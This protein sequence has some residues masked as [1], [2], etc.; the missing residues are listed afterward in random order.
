MNTAL[1]TL[2]PTT[3]SLKTNVFGDKY[4]YNLNRGSFEKIS[5]Q[6]I[7]DAEFSKSLLQEDTLNIIIGTDSGLLPKYV[8][9]QGIPSGSRY[10]FIEPEQILEQ[11]HHHKLLEDLSPEIVCTT[12]DR[13]EEQANKFKITEYSYINGVKSFNAICA[14]QAINDEYTELT[15]QITEAIRKLH[16]LHN[17]S[18]GYQPFIIR[19]IENIAEN[20]LPASILANAYDGKTVIILAGGPSLTSVFPWLLENQ[21]RLVIFSVSRISRQLIAA[22]IEPDFVFSVDP[23]NENID[24]SR[25]MFLF[26]DKTIFI[27]SYHVQPSLINQWHGQSLYLGTRLP[28]KSDLNISNLQGCGPTVTNS[29]LSTAHHFGFKKILLAGFDLCFT[30]EGISHAQGS[31]EQ[32][33]GPRYDPTLLDVETYSGEYRPTSHDYYSALLTLANQAKLI[34]ADHREIINLAPTAAKVEHIKHIPTSEITLPDLNPEDIINV[35]QLIPELTNDLLNIHY[36]AAIGELEKAA[37][38]IETIIKLSQKALNINQSMYSAD[39]RIESYKDKRKLDGIERQ[40]QKKHQ[41]YSTLIKKFGV[42][43]FIKINSPHDSD[44]WDAKKAK[45]LGDIYYKAYQAGATILLALINET[46]TRIKARQEELKPIS[47]INV[48]LAQWNLDKSYR[49]ADLWLQ[50]H[51]QQGISQH[52]ALAL[53]PM[54]DRF[55]Q[56]FSSQDTAFKAKVAKTSTLQMLKS[57]IKLLFRYQKIDE[58]KNLRAGFINDSKHTN[59][60][61]YLLLIE[62]YIAELDNNAEV[63]L[64]HYNNIINIEHSPLLEE[65]LLRIASI[66][67]EQQTPEN[68]FLAIECLAQL[69]PLYLPYQADLARILGKIML[70]IDCYNAYINFFPEDTLSKLKLAALYIEI[71]VYEAAELMLAHILKE[72]PDLESAISLKNQL[73]K[74]KEANENTATVT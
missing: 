6:A 27:N 42:R 46:I 68:A 20:I 13:W 59:K 52:T 45:K 16:Q 32:L 47:D 11:L 41:K 17:T 22:G 34:T 58:L 10:I 61:P 21:N 65:A 9:Q 1:F 69:N 43:Q 29:A 36:Q 64:E 53:K 70:A 25:E 14:Q 30:Q 4:L 44:E 73:A 39:N 62:G 26:G 40:L 67:L 31:D 48:L 12:H 19:Q 50:K 66:S 74:I 18:I 2:A 54:Q 56:V 15:W 8:Q 37:F 63:A 3:S 5:A 35:K 51:S 72:S 28:W 71:K 24:V 7:F 57:K 38:Q 23:Q 55:N 33:A 49:R 60:E